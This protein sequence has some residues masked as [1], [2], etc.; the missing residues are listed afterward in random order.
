MVNVFV[1]IIMLT[2]YTILTT[3]PTN[4]YV[5]MST[6][7]IMTTVIVSTLIVITKLKV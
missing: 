2:S 5:T 7:L 1:M 4:V 6:I 3:M